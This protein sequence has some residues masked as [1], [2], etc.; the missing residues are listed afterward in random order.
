MVILG[1]SQSADLSQGFLDIFIVAADKDS[2]LT[3]WVKYIGTPSFDELGKSLMIM[4]DGNIWALGLISA[5]GFTNGNS[6]VLIMSLTQR[7]ETRFVQNAGGTIVENP[8]G[9]VYSS[10]SDRINIFANT[11]S[12]SFKN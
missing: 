2:L 9:L 5:N 11:N 1:Q 3:Y 10:I 8:A 4:P 6:D 7:G 12:I